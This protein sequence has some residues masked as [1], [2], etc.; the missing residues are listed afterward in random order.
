[1]PEQLVTVVQ[2]LMVTDRLP[3]FAQALALPDQP[4]AMLDGQGDVLAT[5]APASLSA[6]GQGHSRA[7]TVLASLLRTAAGHLRQLPAAGWSGQV[8]TPDGRYLLLLVPTQVQ[9]IGDRRATGDLQSPASQIL[10]KT[11]LAA[12]SAQGGGK[13]V[14]VSAPGD[15]KGNVGGMALAQMGLLRT[16]HPSPLVVMIAGSLA[17]TENTVATVTIISLGGALAVIVLATLLALLVVGTALRPLATITGGAE[18]LATGD[19]GHR[20][21]LESGTDEVGRLATAFN[22]MAAAIAAAFATQ[23]RFVAD[24]SHELRTPL[25]ALRGYTDVLQMGVGADDRATTEGILGAMQEDLGRMSRLVDDLLMLA[26]LDGGAALRRDRLPLAGLLGAAADEGRVLGGG[27]QEIV[28]DAVPDDLVV[29][30]DRD[31]LRQVL[32]NIVG[33]ACA[34]SPPGSRV[35]LSAVRADP[36]AVLCVEDNGPGIGATELSRLGERFFRGDAARSRRTG[37]TGLGLAIARGIVAAHDG[38][39]A[40]DSTPGR[41]TTVTVRL[42]L[43]AQPSPAGSRAGTRPS[44]PHRP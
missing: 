42:P 14:L 44:L 26:R 19:Y 10:L 11:M 24:A 9:V 30:G 36:W 38:V 39:L 40:I 25:T 15:A 41:G 6:R 4:V 43:L 27:A 34:Y 8:A 18:R 1:V 37:G 3:T 35:R 31:R 13:D 16:L 2:A 33:N 12:L 32:S 28:L 20:L 23:R 29:W 17:A 7:T 22:R 5:S 21:N